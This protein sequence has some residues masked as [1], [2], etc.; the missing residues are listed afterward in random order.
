[1]HNIPT[2]IGTIE[3]NLTIVQPIDVIKNDLIIGLD[4]IM[5]R[6]RHVDEDLSSTKKIFIGSAKG[7]QIE[8]KE[9]M[10]RCSSVNKDADT[11]VVKKFKDGLNS[12]H[13]SNSN[14][15]VILHT[16]TLQPIDSTIDNS[17]HTSS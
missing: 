7:V 17:T 16:L 12:N 15:S 8:I 11:L 1:M 13:G 14:D 2:H 10:A 6:S 5:I 9:L 3:C 4:I